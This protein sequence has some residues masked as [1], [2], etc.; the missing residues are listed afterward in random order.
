MA[1][2]LATAAH[3]CPD[4]CLLDVRLA[5]GSGR[6]LAAQLKR[7]P[8]MESV[9]LAMVSGFGDYEEVE[10]SREAGVEHFV[11][12]VDPDVLGKWLNGVRARG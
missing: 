10:A 1:K 2:A 4:V 12:P 7:L 11:K 6:D 5:D 9:T 3:V 8:G